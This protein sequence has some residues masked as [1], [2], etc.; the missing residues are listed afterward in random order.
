MALDDDAAQIA[1]GQPQR[2]FEHDA[3]D[4]LRGKEVV[5]QDDPVASQRRIHLHVLIEAEAEE[6]RHALA[7]VDHRERR[8]GARLDDLEELGVLQRDAVQLQPYFDDGLA[9]VIG[10]G[11][12]ERLRQEKESDSRIRSADLQ[13][14]LATT[15]KTPSS[16]VMSSA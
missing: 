16:P 11:G 4:A 10:N 9:D 1:F 12:F 2:S 7:H 3:P 14:G 6:V 15:L 5:G 13:V 8:A